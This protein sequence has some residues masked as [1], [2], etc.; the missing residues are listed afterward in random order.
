MTINKLIKM[1]IGVN[2]IHVKKANICELENGTKK[3]VFDVEPHKNQQCRCPLCNNQKRLPKYDSSKNVNSWRGLDCGGIIV[4]LRSE[5]HR[6]SCP[7]HGVITAGV[8][9][10]F[11]NS[12]F[13]KDFDMSVTWLAKTLNKSAVAEY[14]RISWATVGRC[15]SRAFDA[16][17][18]NHYSRLENLER[19]GIDETSYSKGHRYITTVINHDTNTVVWVGKGHGKTVLEGFFKLLSKEQKEGIKVV[20]GDG[21]RWISECVEEH[22]PNALRCTDPYHVVEW[23]T[24]ALDEIRKEVWREANKALKEVKKEHKRGKGRPRKDDVEAKEVSEAKQEAK[25]IK[26]SRYALGKAPENLTENQE[27]KLAQIKA[28]NP[29]LYRGYELKESLRKLLKVKDVVEATK[30]IDHWISW[31]R[32]SRIDS[33]KELAL[34]IKRHRQYILNFI[35]TGISNARVEA[36]NNKISLLVHRSYGFKN[37]K[38]MVDMIMLICSNLVISLP[39]RPQKQ[40]KTA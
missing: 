13:T 33:F 27:V 25:E 38:N 6:V 37:Y 40:E 35:E 19:I 4:E 18:P 39:N 5:T 34:K 1:F 32:R 15:I 36:N 21:A 16:L 31:A 11:P 3:I 12:R 23:A 14:M 22:C 24:E 7:V 28:N 29:R 30:E 8:P 20:S 10:A 9:W 17:E 2:G 26:G